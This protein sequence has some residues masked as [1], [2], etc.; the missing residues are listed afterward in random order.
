LATTWQQLGTSLGVIVA[1]GLLHIANYVS[2]TNFAIASF[3]YVFFA[4]ALINLSCQFLLNRLDK[5]DGQSLIS[6]KYKHEIT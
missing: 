5:N 6:N 2:A 4:L 1:A 3:H